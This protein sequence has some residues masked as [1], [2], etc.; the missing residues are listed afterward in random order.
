MTLVIDKKV[1]Y[2]KT[3]IINRDCSAGT[4]WY[5]NIKS[6]SFNPDAMIIRAITYSAGTNQGAASDT[7]TYLVWSS[8]T[9]DFVAAFNC[10]GSSG[11]TGAGV[12]SQTC[13]SNPQSYTMFK[14]PL[15][16]H[17]PRF[18]IYSVGANG[19]VLNNAIIG[20]LTLTIDF[21]LFSKL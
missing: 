14:N 7:E 10:S 21:I 19:P 12:S 8:I 5:D 17:T 3:L 15:L 18:Q 13:V 11:A 20:N 4:D 16:D 2:I 9:N 6:L 1:D